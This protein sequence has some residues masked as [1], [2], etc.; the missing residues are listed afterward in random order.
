MCVKLSCVGAARK[1]VSPGLVAWE[2]AR[3]RGCLQLLLSVSLSRDVQFW[4]P[5]GVPDSGP[6]F[7]VPTT[8]FTPLEYG[9]VGLSE[10]EAVARHGEEHVEVS[11][12]LQG[13]EER[14]CQ[15]AVPCGT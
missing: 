8:V 11:Q 13:T 15:D 1:Q 7:Q 9:C 2:P 5:R 6:A 3:L 12:V 10:E 4:V 14:G